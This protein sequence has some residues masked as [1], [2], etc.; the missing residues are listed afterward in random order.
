M[1]HRKLETRRQLGESERK[2]LSSRERVCLRPG[3]QDQWPPELLTKRVSEKLPLPCSCMRVRGGFWK[4]KETTRE[5]A[6]SCPSHNVGHLS[7]WSL[8]FSVGTMMPTAALSTCKPSRSGDIMTSWWDLPT[9]LKSILNQF[10][11]SVNV[12]KKASLHESDRRN[13]WGTKVTMTCV[14]TPGDIHGNT[15]SL[16]ATLEPIS[17][18]SQYLTSS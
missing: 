3:W 16:R 9:G 10:S 12:N 13:K 15:T 11:S 7:H 4:G 5:A 14:R 17:P 2:R 18:I 8:C 1:N 6:M